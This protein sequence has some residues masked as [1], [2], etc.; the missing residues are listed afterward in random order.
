LGGCFLSGLKVGVRRAWAAS[1]AQERSEGAI[2]LYEGVMQGG[3][4]TEAAEH[5]YL[6]FDRLHV[7]RSEVRGQ[8]LLE[9]C[10]LG[11]VATTG[12]ICSG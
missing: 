9:R 5:R 3:V 8:A 7:S 11:V 10:D 12:G 6:L 2:N 1:L 4:Q